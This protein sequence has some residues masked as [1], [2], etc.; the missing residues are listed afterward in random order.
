MQIAQP[1][2][3]IGTSTAWAPRRGSGI[4]FTAQP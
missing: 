2:D 1:Y 3:A 4:V